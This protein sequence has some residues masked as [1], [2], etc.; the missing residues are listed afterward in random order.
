MPRYLAILI[1]GLM[2][3]Q[4]CA[5]D[6]EK[7]PEDLPSFSFEGERL[8]QEWSS[9]T[10]VTKVEFPDEA[11]L[12]EMMVTYPRLAHRMMVDG[13]KPDAHPAVFNAIQNSDY[14]PL[15]AELQQVWRLHFSGEFEKAYEHGMALGTFGEIPAIYSRL[16][17]A[18][19]LIEDSDDK[20]E[21]FQRAAEQSN[22]GLTLVPEYPFAEFGLVYAK[23]RMLELMSTG[24]ARSS[25][26][27][28][29]AQDKL[30]KLRKKF[31]ERA[32]YPLTNGG[33]QAGIVER[34]GSFLG[35]ITYGATESNADDD[36]K[37]ALKLVSD[38]PLI[39]NEAAVGYSRL[40][41]DD[42]RKK[43][44]KL[45]NT[46]VQLEPVS[47]EEALNQHHCAQMLNEMTKDK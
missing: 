4:A 15:A 32:A 47:A 29:I 44:L 20:M 35:S 25:G 30:E 27:I 37:Q 3:F 24:E 28:S 10:S 23:V 40:D 21:E 34:I 46:C 5:T 33:L 9:L 7:Y 39:Y 1:A 41:A 22:E 14:A 43:I 11:W 42:Y 8:Q 17:H 13:S 18:T 12:K 31:P 19:L 6:W 38:M 36:F 2:S 16:I 45:L 26:Y